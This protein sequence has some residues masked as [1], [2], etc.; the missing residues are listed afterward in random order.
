LE[1]VSQAIDLGAKSQF[2]SEI[3]NFLGRN[4]SISSLAAENYGVLPG[5]PKQTTSGE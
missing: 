5:N 2:F 4:T 3:P 1:K